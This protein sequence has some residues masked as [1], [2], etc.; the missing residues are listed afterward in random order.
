M[1]RSTVVYAATTLF[2]LALLGANLAPCSAEAG[3]ES[4]GAEPSIN[5]AITAD[6][7][8]AASV[9]L[10]FGLN[11]FNDVANQAIEDLQNFLDARG[12]NLSDVVTAAGRA[13]D[14]PEPTDSQII[15]TAMYLD[16]PFLAFD[17]TAR[18]GTDA[19]ATFSLNSFLPIDPIASGTFARAVLDVDLIDANND[20][21]A[22]INTLSIISP[23]LTEFLGVT[24]DG[25]VPHLTPF[26]NDLIGTALSGETNGFVRFDTG[27]VT[28]P[29]FDSGSNLIEL[30]PRAEFKISAGDEVRLRGL[31]TIDTIESGLLTP[32]Q[33]FPVLDVVIAI[34]EPSAATSLLIGMTLLAPLLALRRRNVVNSS[35]DDI[36]STHTGRKAARIA[37]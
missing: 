8:A 20:G 26:P 10:L 7:V 28:G 19:E 35:N 34:P 32:E 12:K 2:W 25:F 30:A 37:R 27:V 1:A 31:Y 11:P 9:A 24:S 13:F 16:D 4:P 14:D 22:E 21:T 17:V 15:L 18:N 33:A 6:N 3:D 29:T 23:S 5:A 36:G